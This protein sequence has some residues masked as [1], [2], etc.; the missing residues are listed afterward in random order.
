MQDSNQF[1]T[2]LDYLLL[3]FF[4]TLA[5]FFNTARSL[6]NR[7]NARG[8]RQEQSLLAVISSPQLQSKFA[9]CGFLGTSLLTIG[10]G[11]IGTL[12]RAGWIGAAVGLFAFEAGV[13]A[14]PELGVGR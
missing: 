10:L 7:I 2:L 11:I 6:S 12:S 9:Q 5:E 4:V 1:I 3:P 13:R 8:P 14:Y